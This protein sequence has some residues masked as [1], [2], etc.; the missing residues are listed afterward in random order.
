[1]NLR[2]LAK[3]CQERNINCDGCP[4]KEVCDN[5]QYMLE[6]ASP[7]TIVELVDNNRVI[8]I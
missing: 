1:M 5:L 3:K 7:V 4:Y 2:E 6:D 8:E